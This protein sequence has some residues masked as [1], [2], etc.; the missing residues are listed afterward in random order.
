[1]AAGA[2][3]LSELHL[4]HPKIMVLCG[5]IKTAENLHG[6]LRFFESNSKPLYLDPWDTLPFEAVSPQLHITAERI[7]TLYNLASKQRFICVASVAAMVQ[8]TI[9][10]HFIKE[11]SFNLKCGDTIPRTELLQIFDRNGYQRV[12]LVEETGQLAVRGGVIDFAPAGS[13]QAYRL[14]LCDDQIERISLFDVNTQR[15][16]SESNTA[17]ILP[18]RELLQLSSPG[19]KALLHDAICKIKNRAAELELL[20]SETAK[21]TTALSE[22]LLY[23]GIE[24][25][26]AVGLAPLA[27]VFDYLPADTL[28]VINDRNAIQRVGDEFQQLLCERESR[29]QNEPLLFPAKEMFFLEPLQLQTHTETYQRCYLN[30]LTPQAGTETVTPINIRSSSHTALALKL[31]TKVG[32]GNALQPL[33]EALDAWRSKNYNVSF[34]VGSTE[35]ALRLQRMLLSIDWEADIIQ[36]GYTEWRAKRTPHP[37]AILLGHLSEGAALA[38]AKLV[39]IAEHEI[40][41]QRSYRSRRS[42]RPQSLQRLLGSISQLQSGDLIVH[43]DYG[44][45]RYQG[46]T[47]RKVE[48]VESDFVQIQYADSTLFLPI[49]NIGRIQKYVTAEDRPPALDRL[50]SNRWFQVKRKVRQSAVAMAGDL[51]KLYAAR[52][53]ARGWRFDPE[54]AEDERFADEFP[55]DETPD[56]LAAIRAT[57]TDMAADK[58][59]DRLVCGDVGFG[60]TEV[61]LRAAYKCAQ[62]ARQT[63]LLVPTTIL[64]EQHKKTFQDRFRDYPVKI[65][66]LSRFYKPAQNKQT[67]EELKDGTLD[68]VIGTHKLLHRNIQFKDLG[69]LIIDEEHRFGV[70]QKE[71]LK[72]LKRQ[73]DVITLTAT[74]IPRTLHMS[75]LNLR[76]ISVINT[77]PLDRH[78]I[79]TYLATR[80]DTLIR[81]AV[82]REHR[83][84]GQV[85]YVHNRVQSIYSVGM[86]LARLIPEVRLEVAHGQ[87][88]EQQL[89]DIMQRFLRHEIDVL[90]CTT[91][92]ESGLDI[93]NCNTIIIDRADRLGLAQLYQL[94]GRVGRSDRQAYCYLL[95]PQAKKL[96]PDALKRL[97]VLQAI[98]DLG[99]GFNLAIRDLEI[100]GA[101]NLL[102]REQSGNMHAVGYELYTKILREAILS[103]K[104]EELELEEYIDPEVNLG[105]GA[106]IPESYIPDISERLVLYQ[107][108]TAISSSAEALE[109]ELEISDRFG[110]PCPEVVNLI[111]VMR[112]R[113]LLRKHGVTSA[114]LSKQKLTLSLSP[115]A[116]ID[117]AQV[118]KLIKDAPQRY[119]LGRDGTLTITLS[120]QEAESNERLYELTEALLEEIRFQPG[121]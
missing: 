62:H 67:L 53:L 74:P 64:V 48:G 98:D 115:L 105:V 46:L 9:P 100:R 110:N 32:S 18:V 40:F 41:P 118:L 4:K 88:P 112:Y 101:G 107:R 1:P 96:G 108:L 90:V 70:K 85:F 78:A 58:P 79:M 11:L 102:G 23:P 44:I 55:F 50:G 109:L 26:I 35:R 36:G 38:E 15:S 93:P 24:L 19:G 59:M 103:I 57:L 54:G 63:A 39:F 83:R 10:P 75:L 113:G 28:L 8:M 80:D 27:T 66:A 37:V 60:K 13:A 2:W 73:V 45:G 86:E 114:R 111:K 92:I 84:G 7:H 72:Q 14:E 120:E 104:G 71:R 47:N 81:D 25:A 30:D 119:R 87:M 5:D 68:I 31:K 117:T 121:R 3:L 22:D 49:Q 12:S 77:P 6:D 61:A 42:A 56:Q 29:M 89:E 43:E 17:E 94:R 82:L 99:A 51:I 16:V 69:L 97:K 21:I 95:A 116:K 34:V 76:D 52:S 65:G 20:P 33:A 91:I 106:Y